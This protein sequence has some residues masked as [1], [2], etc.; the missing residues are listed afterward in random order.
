[1]AILARNKKAFY[2]YV[3]IKKLEAGIQLTGAEVKSAKKARIQLKDSFVKIDKN[4]EVHL[5][6][7]Y[8][9]PYSK[10][11]Q[12][13]YQPDQ[14]RKLLLHE[15]EIESLQASMKGQNLTIVPLKV[16][17]TRKGLIKLQIALAKGKRKY[18]KKRKLQEI[19][20][21]R[22]IERTLKRYG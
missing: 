7:C 12:T 10:A 13:D 3:I 5:Y 9:A 2:D 1:M 17:T 6:N 21:K 22:E 18:D 20:K 14:V 16:Y 8:I 19:E 4:G 15:A 11:R